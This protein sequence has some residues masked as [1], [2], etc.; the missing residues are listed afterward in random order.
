MQTPHTSKCRTPGTGA[1]ALII[2]ALTREPGS[3]WPQAGDNTT[4]ATLTIFRHNNSLHITEE[5]TMR[6]WLCETSSIEGSHVLK[7]Q[8]RSRWAL[9]GIYCIIIKPLPALTSMSPVVQTTSCAELNSAS[10][11]I[12][13]WAR[14]SKG[15]AFFLC[16]IW[17]VFVSQNI[18]VF[19][20]TP[21]NL[22]SVHILT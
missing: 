21:V 22:I 19:K 18:Y 5:G 10:K 12:R 15:S 14:F 16:C 8:K 13:K 6:V 20:I 2:I 11:C 1:C 7:T 9:C 17:W 3:L 4:C